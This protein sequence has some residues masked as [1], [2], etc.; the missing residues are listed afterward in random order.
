MLAQ[1]VFLED[2]RFLQ[3]GTGHREESCKKELLDNV[4]PQYD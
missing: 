1:L 3:A 2:M 4:H